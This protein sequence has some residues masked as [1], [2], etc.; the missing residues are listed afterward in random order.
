MLEHLAA[1]TELSDAELELF[2][3]AAGRLFSE[4]FLVRSIETHEKLYRF[5]VRNFLL[6]ESYFALAGWGLRRDENLGV[7]AF[8]GPASARLQLG[9]EES[10]AL[11]VLRLLY[12]EKAGIVTLHGERTILQREFQ[13][14]LSALWGKALKKT[15]LQHIFRRFQVLKLIR[16]LGDET[17]PECVIILYPSL[18]FVLEGRSIEELAEKV[19]SYVQE[20]AEQNGQ[21]GIDPDSDADAIE[22]E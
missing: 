18:P 14:K 22:E 20:S 16:V 15:R 21:D 2:R 4:G 1:I 12:E 9:I 5:T 13:E 19:R 10:V 3:T 6:F 17:D 7:V 8:T 11:L